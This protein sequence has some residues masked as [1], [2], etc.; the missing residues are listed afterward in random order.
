MKRTAFLAS[1]LGA[2]SLSA[3]GALAQPPGPPP[4]P[5]HGPPPEMRLQH[6]LQNLGLSGDQETK[7]QAIL[8]GAKTQ[9]EQM[10]P[11]MEAAFDQMH[12]LLKADPPDEAAIMQQAD[13]IGQ[14]K[15]EEHKTMLHTLLA[16]RAELTPE[17]RQQLE[18][19]KKH[20]RPPWKH[21]HPGP[22][23]D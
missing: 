22:Q 17:Q 15:T 7:V 4:G 2:L 14:L 9:R 20:H 8:D 1:L 12:T 5:H 3:G 21:R 23:D 6:D 19:M 13:K 10:R 11:Q 18:A 16:V